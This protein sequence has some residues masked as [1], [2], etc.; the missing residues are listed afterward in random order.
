MRKP[1]SHSDIE[2]KLLLANEKLRSKEAQLRFISEHSPDLILRLDPQ[3]AVTWVSPSCS[4]YG[5]QIEQLLGTNAQDLIHPDELAALS[6]RKVATFASVEDS[7]E[8]NWEY[9]IRKNDG[10]WVWVEENPTIIRDRSGRAVE[11][12]SVLR[13]ISDRKRAERAAGDIQSGMLLPRAALARISPRVEVDA[14][15]HP[16]RNVGGDLYDAFIFDED[17][18]FFLIGDVTGKGVAAALF[19]ALAKAL[20]H[21]LILR[22]PEDL[23][24]AMSAIGAELTRNNSEEMALSLLVGRLDLDSGRLQLCNAGHEDP[25]ILSTEGTVSRLKLEGGPPLCVAKDYRYLVETHHLARGAALVALTD[26]VTEAENPA[27][28]PF[29]RTRT[30]AAL[31]ATAARAPLTALL[32]GLVAAVEAFVEGA[33]PSDDLTALTLRRPL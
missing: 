30:L 23:G 4:R 7:Q 13:D 33:H 5:Y 17:R 22:S 9:R 24:A 26:G 28:E 21:S 29:G 11:I 20:S 15:L 25:M 3:S 1:T 8:A 10:G 18:L 16:A 12:V 2:H 31:E 14:I 32:D 27:G 6:A 19:M